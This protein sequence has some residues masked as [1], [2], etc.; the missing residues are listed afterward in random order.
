MKFN[1]LHLSKN[2]IP[3]AKTL[4]TEDLS[5]ITFNYLCENSPN[6]LCHFWNHKSFFTTQLVYII[7]AQTLHTFDKN[8]PSKCKFSDFSLLKL[9]FI[10]FLMSYSKQKVTF[11][12]N[13]GSLFSFMRELFCTFSAETVGTWFGQKEPIKVQNFR[14]LSAHVKLHQIYT[15]ILGSLKYIKILAKKYDILW[16][17]MISYDILYHILWLWRLMRNLKKNWSVVSKMTRIWWNLMRALESLQK[18]H[19]HLLLVQSI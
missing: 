12:L 16:L 4:Y 9:K 17:L 3:S 2:Y 5:N 7:S 14:L 18:L 11:S 6:S 1:G 13:F 19:F 8:I 10:K 15:L